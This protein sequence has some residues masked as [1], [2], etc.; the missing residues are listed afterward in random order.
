MTKQGC[1]VRTMDNTCVGN[2]THMRYIILS[3]LKEDIH[4]YSIR[5]RQKN[6]DERS[7]RASETGIYKTIRGP[8]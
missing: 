5:K 6:R 4:D 8:H 3:C 7:K 2:Q 1:L